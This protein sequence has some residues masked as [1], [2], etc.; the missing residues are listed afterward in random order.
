MSTAH[1]SRAKAM[2][3]F[4][5]VAVVLVCGASAAIHEDEQ[6]LRDWVMRF[7]GNV[8]Y[9]AVPPTAN[10]TLVYVLSE[11]GAVTALDLTPRGALNLTWRQV[12]S[13]A[14]QCLAAADDAVL[15]VDAKGTAY[16]LS[17]EQ[18][19]IATT[20]VLQQPAAL[21]GEPAVAV[22]CSIVDGKVTVAMYHAS[23]GGA[24][25]YT[26][27]ITTEDEVIGSSAT[28]AMGPDVT[29][30]RLGGGKHV[31]AT[32][33]KTG[34]TT[35][36][37]ATTGAKVGSMEGTSA[38]VGLDGEIVLV[39]KNGLGG[40]VAKDADFSIQCERCSATHII[41]SETGAVATAGKKATTVTVTTA[42]TVMRVSFPT[43]EVSLPIN[44]SAG[45]AY[46]LIA[47]TKESDGMVYALV[48]KPSRH[49]VLVRSDGAVMWERREGLSGAAATLIVAPPNQQ[50]DR[51]HF[52]K[53]VLMASRY[54]TLY[55][56]PLSEMGTK[57][58]VLTDFSIPLLKQM[59]VASMAQVQVTAMTQIS[60]TT[61]GVRCE[62]DGTTAIVVIDLVTKE[63]TKVRLFD[64]KIVITPQY[65]IAR[66]LTLEG[67]LDSPQL[68]VYVADAAKGLVEGYSVSNATKRA[69]PAWSIKF[70]YPVVAHT[71]GQDSSRTAIVNDL[72]VYP[73]RTGA[74]PVDEVR[75]RYPTRNVVV[76][77]Y[78]EPADEDHLPTLVITAVDAVTGGV[79]AT[80]RH[81]D[82]EGD[83]KMAIIEH[84]LIY[85]FL[86]ASK[87]RYCFGVWE[88]FEEE[89]G[90]AVSKSAGATLPMVVASFFAKSDRV[91]S[92]RA[93][94]PPVIA[95][96]TL[97]LYG[98]PVADM[99]VTTSNGAIARKSI[100]MAF[101]TG[102]VAVVELNS[103]LAGNQ[104]VMPNTENKQLSHV[105]LHS[106]A[107]AT[108]RYRLAKPRG[109][110]TAP[111]NLESSC[112]V[113]V[114]GLDLF[115][116]RSS[117]GKPFDLLNTDFNKPLLV[118]LVAAFAVL[119]FLVRYLVMRKSLN[120]LWE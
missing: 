45:T 89:Q 103:L 25:A 60:E 84:T 32:A 6:G 14:P 10:P 70:P 107:L 7:A 74:E 5:A 111:T 101:E 86:D 118:A 100:V 102:R 108:H 57:I 22:A 24:R 112:H 52:N 8:R 105:F 63:V 113:V 82:V 31:Y 16:L 67:A 34:S 51:F 12:F 64:E 56:I 11:E 13:E 91:F 3:L 87:M 94:R 38:S 98:G 9:A 120:A 66:D 117:A 27:D 23:T 1:V 96:S 97:G 39:K 30:L 77:A 49:L 33:T 116:V 65:T 59:P 54:G 15:A 72:R 48:K 29:F 104:M 28:I 47:F 99:G 109:V 19:F 81:Q 119:S 50:L 88:M 90:S 73:N 17:P 44:A 78:Y 83:V 85:Y 20:F 106:S 21:A 71:S 4:A 79:L 62:A 110:T 61:V 46:P 95:A 75:H 55:S 18:G 43:K 58:E 68:L 80:T 93:S 69:T 42:G 26:F 92:S 76:A 41:D 114:T 36:Y 35:Q 53:Q 115:Y 40:T 37:D 2:L